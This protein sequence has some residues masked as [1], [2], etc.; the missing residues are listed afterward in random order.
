M[1]LLS[2]VLL[3]PITGPV[4]GLAFI[5]EQIKE[6]V[7]EELLG[8]SSR[9]EEELMSLGLRYELGEISEQAYAEQE[10]GL[11]ERLN[12]IRAEQ[13]YWL[14]TEEMEGKVDEAP[15]EHTESTDEC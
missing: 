4:R 5:F 13:E 14:Q 9:I 11:L 3:F 15:L 12:N 6:Q 2:D 1:G 7:D 10:T 8:E